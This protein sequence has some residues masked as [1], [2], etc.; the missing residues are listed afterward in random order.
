[1]AEVQTPP[2]TIT[3]GDKSYAAFSEEH[4]LADI[5]RWALSNK[6]DAEEVI[7]LLQEML[8]EVDRVLEGKE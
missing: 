4:T 3:V 6:V 1:M 8:E 2:V 7:R 5:A